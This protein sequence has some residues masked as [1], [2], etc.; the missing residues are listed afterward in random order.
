[1]A[2]RQGREKP[3]KIEQRKERVL[4]SGPQ[5][6]QRA[7]LAS[8]ID[9]GQARGRGKNVQKEEPKWAGGLSSLPAFWVSLPSRLEDVLSFGG[10]GLVV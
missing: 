9:T 10:G 6:E 3:A 1:M 5:V 4:E 7:L 8:P 2:E